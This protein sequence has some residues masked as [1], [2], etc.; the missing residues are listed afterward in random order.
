MGKISQVE[1]SLSPRISAEISVA[2]IRS[3]ALTRRIV[4]LLGER[5]EISGDV[6]RLGD[7]AG[8]HLMELASPQDDEDVGA[9][10]DLQT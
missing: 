6:S 4:F 1:K 8:K 3:T 7:L 9:I 2:V 5:H 10:A